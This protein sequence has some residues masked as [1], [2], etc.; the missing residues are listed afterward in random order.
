MEIKGFSFHMVTSPPEQCI[1][2]ANNEY[3]AWKA[4]RHAV[5]FNK[6]PRKLRFWLVKMRN[7]RK[8]AILQ[9]FLR[10]R[11]KSTWVFC[12]GM[13]TALYFFL[14]HIY[15]SSAAAWANNS[16]GKCIGFQQISLNSPILVK[17]AKPE[18][19]YHRSKMAKNLEA[20]RQAA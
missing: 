13:C 17:N 19:I 11:G 2:L 6:S 12:F 3:Y 18:K 5:F 9:N 1:F 15:F 10:N 4:L 20:S 7:W 16:R 14:L 8:F